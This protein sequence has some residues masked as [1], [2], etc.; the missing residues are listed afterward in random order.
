ME[1]KKERRISARISEHQYRLIDRFS[2]EWDTTT[3]EVVRIIL[4]Y[5]LRCLDK[6]K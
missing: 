3:S 5:I 6:G 4:D 1:E 2:K